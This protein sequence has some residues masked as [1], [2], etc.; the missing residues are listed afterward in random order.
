VLGQGTYTGM[1]RRADG[2]WRVV[3]HAFVVTGSGGRFTLIVARSPV[4]AEPRTLIP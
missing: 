2:T 3:R 4:T 1:W